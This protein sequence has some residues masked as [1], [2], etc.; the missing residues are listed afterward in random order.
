MRTPSGAVWVWLRQGSESNRFRP[1]LRLRPPEPRR[2]D[3]RV[4]G[5]GGGGWEEGREGQDGIHDSTTSS[6]SCG[7]AN[8]AS[9]TRNDEQRREDNRGGGGGGDGGDG[10]SANM[11]S[12][13]A[14]H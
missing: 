13:L 11:G 3:V 6:V 1:P 5:T 14:N 9:G 7:K 8:A 2:G 12:K 10:L 4:E